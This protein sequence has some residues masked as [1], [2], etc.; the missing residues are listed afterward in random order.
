MNS[1][2]VF[3]NEIGLKI[4]SYLLRALSDDPRSKEVS[5][6]VLIKMILCEYYEVESR[7][8]RSKNI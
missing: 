1:K 7:H 3:K 2:Q 6:Q 5:T 8:T 4:P